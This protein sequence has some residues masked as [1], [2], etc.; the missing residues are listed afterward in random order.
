M[1]GA[2]ALHTSEATQQVFSISAVIMHPEYQPMTH[3]SDICLLQVSCLW[4]GVAGTRCTYSLS[5]ATS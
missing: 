3:T 1:L 4:G 5:L 2:H